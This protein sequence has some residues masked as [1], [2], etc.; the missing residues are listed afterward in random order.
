MDDVTSVMWVDVD[1]ISVMFCI[2]VS[3][4]MF[5]GS[6]M[7]KRPSNLKTNKELIIPPSQ[8]N[9]LLRRTPIAV[10]VIVHLTLPHDNISFAPQSSVI[11]KIVR[12]LER[13]VNLR[14]DLW[15]SCHETCFRSRSGMLW[16]CHS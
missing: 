7:H 13:R 3:T 14:L 9:M 2:I 15:L 6:A 4:V 5:I 12:L 11:G 1:V 8:R 10:I 16:R